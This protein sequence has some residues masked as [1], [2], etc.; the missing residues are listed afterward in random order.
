MKIRMFR[1]FRS[2]TKSKF[3]SDALKQS[4]KNEG[5]IN[6]KKEIDIHAVLRDYQVETFFPGENYFI[7]QK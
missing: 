6:S 2:V 4:L 1:I 3:L 5:I 7:T